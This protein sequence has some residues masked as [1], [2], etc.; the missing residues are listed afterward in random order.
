MVSRKGAR[1]FTPFVACFACAGE[2]YIEL[3]GGPTR[4]CTV[5]RGTRKVRWIEA[6][7]AERARRAR[8][9]RILG[10]VVGMVR[11]GRRFSYDMRRSGPK[12]VV[13]VVGIEAEEFQAR[14][15]ETQPDADEVLAPATE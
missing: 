4:R 15:G 9:L 2:G 6:R 13:L 3:P 8:A 1:Q 14:W 11:D 12:S 7:D 10:V 5:C